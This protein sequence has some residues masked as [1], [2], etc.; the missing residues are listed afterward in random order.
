MKRI[1]GLLAALGVLALGMN[2]AVAFTPGNIVVLRIGNGSESLTNTGNTTFLDEYTTNGTYV[3]TL[4]MPTNSYGANAPLICYG[5]GF[6]EGEITLSQDGRFLL[7][8]GFG[9]APG[10]Y[11]NSA[12]S[13]SYASNEV[14]RVVGVVDGQGHINTT[15]V[16][17]NT[18]ENGEEVRSATS[19]DGTNLWFTGDTTGIKATTVGS[20][21]STQVEK[22]AT[23]V[24]QVSIY[25][26][27]MYFTAS[28]GIRVATNPPLPFVTNALVTLLPGTLTNNTSPFGFAMFNLNG[29]ST[30]DTLY[31][32]D[33]DVSC[34]T[35]GAILKY[36]LN[37]GTWVN[38][39]TICAE[40]AVY[41]TGIQKGTNVTLFI[42]DS[43]T[44]NGNQTLYTGVDT[45]GFNGNPNFLDLSSGGVLLTPVGGTFGVRG[46]AMAPTGNQPLTGG[47]NVC[48]VSQNYPFNQVGPFGGPFSPTTNYYSVA[49]FGTASFTYSFIA[50]AASWL[51]ASPSSVSIPVGGSITVAVYDNAG[52]NTQTPGLHNGVNI[53]FNAPGGG[54][55]RKVSLQVNALSITPSTNW[56]AVGSPGGPTF[57]P[58][59]QVYVISNTTPNTIGWAIS[60]AQPW[61]S[62]NGSGSVTG[63]LG[64]AGTTN[65]TYSIN[66]TANT[67]GVGVYVDTITLSNAPPPAAA[68]LVAQIQVTLAVGFG[69]FDDYST[70][71]QNQNL[72]GQNGWLAISSPGVNPYQVTN[73][74]LVIEGP[75][76]G[77]LVCDAG[78]ENIKDW[79]TTT[80]G[81]NNGAQSF[82]YAGM[83]VSVLDSVASSGPPFAFEVED[84]VKQANPVSFEFDAGSAVPS[85][86]GYVWGARKSTASTWTFGTTVRSYGT[87][88][89]VIDVGDIVNSNCWIFVNPPAGLNNIGD[90]TNNLSPDA[91]NPASAGGVGEDTGGTE[92]AGGWV[93]GQFG[94]STCQ[95]GMIVTKFAM[96]TNY[97]QV[98]NFLAGIVPPPPAP[99]VI[100][101][102]SRTNGNNDVV[103]VWNG[104]VG[105]NIVQVSQGTAN[106]SYTNSFT[107]LATNV[108]GSAGSASYTDVG[109]GTN[110][111][112]RYYRIDLRQ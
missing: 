67:L 59:S 82:M 40:S 88:Y 52:A 38:V 55:A 14:P 43:G 75:G 100:T 28:T 35:T 33:T 72:S 91:W 6:A 27:Q 3:S 93:W 104:Q 80:I 29:G 110:R 26:N 1:L 53:I 10:Q 46:I 11:T 45:T 73:N 98:Y 92:G 95:P 107:D 39:G 8:A 69:I 77:T 56:Q 9:V 108:L 58:G 61:A 17:T 89:M 42:T 60:T 76:G 103:L 78:E 64:V 5:S 31:V 65:I 2:N 23:N 94:A 37:G 7:V 54:V 32:V 30:P 83:L 25:S 96:S 71:G 90:L 81:T 36:C 41:M 84:G 12:L 97:T 70:Y 51:S 105:T 63:T 21:L 106:G 44:I 87:Q 74:E 50:G 24:R 18:F 79:S 48:S 102:I 13:S 111:P 99:F 20:T 4:M 86:G 47:P 57:T 68:A 109:G 66:P 16:Q 19:T 112:N 15:T 101:S 85:G 34:T 62:V 49:N 22:T